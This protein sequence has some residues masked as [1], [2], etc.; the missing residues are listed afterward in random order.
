MVNSEQEAASPAQT[1]TGDEP[2]EAGWDWSDWGDP[3]STSEES[4]AAAAIEGTPAGPASA[5]SPAGTGA[6]S[7]DWDWGETPA[8]GAVTATRR[9]GTGAKTP[10]PGRRGRVVKPREQRVASTAEPDFQGLAERKGQI[11]RCLKGSCLIT[12]RPLAVISRHGA[13]LAWALYLALHGGC[14]LPPLDPRWPA[15]H[16]LLEVCEIEQI[17]VDESHRRRARKRPFGPA[18]EPALSRRLLQPA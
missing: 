2:A 8:A 4:A 12:G 16:G 18:P 13:R 14:L 1:P 5:E 11:A 15:L 3:G 10:S 17:L 9:A 6:E 7:R